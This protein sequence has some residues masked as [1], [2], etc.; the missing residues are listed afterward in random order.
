MKSVT[1]LPQY[2]ES[3]ANDYKRMGIKYVEL[4]VSD[5]LRPE[6]LE[7]C[8]RE[9]PKLEERLGVKIRFLAAI[10]RHSE[11]SY[12][13]Q[14]TQRIRALQ[15]NPYIVGVD[16]MG[17][18]TNSTLDFS[19]VLKELSEY[20]KVKNPNFQIR[21]H[22]GENKNYLENIKNAIRLGATRIGHGIYGVDEETLQL[23]KAHG[24]IIEFNTNSNLALKNIPNANVLPIKNYLEAGVRVTIGSDG[25]G[26][27]QTSS[28]AESSVFERMG[29]TAGEIA[30]ISNSDK[31]YVATME[32]TFAS[33]LGSSRTMSCSRIFSF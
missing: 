12:N 24:T 33:K 4:S 20:R 16:I 29:L 27:Y 25:H 17:N 10:W 14:V 3:L 21:V 2:L 26:L 22:A 32:R 31:I 11:K 6:W 5:I 18:E 15:K 8:E 9:L 30:K 7:I 1:A 19:D 23:A 13:A 28:F